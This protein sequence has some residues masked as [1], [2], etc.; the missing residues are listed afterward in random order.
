MTTQAPQVEARKLGDLEETEA[1]A[2]WHMALSPRLSMDLSLTRIHR[3]AG[4]STQL[5]NPSQE[6]GVKVDLRWQERDTTTTLHLARRE[7]LAS[8]TPFS[9]NTNGAWTTA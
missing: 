4:L 7:S 9:S 8:Y 5:S 2:Q 1:T 6:R 3:T